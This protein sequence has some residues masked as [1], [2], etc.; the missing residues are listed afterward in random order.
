MGRS[1]IKKKR[2]Q[3]NG[4][5]HHERE[6]ISFEPGEVTMVLRSE[7]RRHNLSLPLSSFIGRESEVAEVKQRLLEVRLLTLIGP[8]G[9]G[10][11]RLA[12]R[13]AS[14]LSAEYADGAWL[15]EFAPLTEAVLIPQAVASALNVLEEAE[16]TLIDT[17]ADYLL[18]QQTLLVLDNCE[19]LVVACAQ[20]AETLLQACPGLRILATSRE[21]LG[22]P[23]EAVWSVPPLSLPDPQAWRDHSSGQNALP[24]YK[25]SEAVQLFVARAAAAFPAFSLTEQNGEWVADVC[26]KLDGMPLAIELAA[27]RV[28]TLSV[29]QIAE[30]LSDRFHL[31]K[32]GSRTA[33]SRQQTLEAALDWSYSLLSNAEQELL[34]KLSVFAGG[35]TLEAAEAVCGDH[36]IEARNVLDLLTQLANKSLV[37][38]ERVPGQKTRFRLLETIRQYGREKL[39][40]AG[41]AGVVEVRHRDWYMKMAI[42]AGPELKGSEQ[43]EWIEWLE[44][45]HDNLRAALAWSIE[46]DTAVALQLAEKL[47]QFWFMRGHHFGEGIEWLE[48]VLS[49]E[50]APGQVATRARAFRWLGTLTYLQGNYAAAR[51]AYEQ[52]LALSQEMQ[53]LDNIAEAFFYLADTAAIQGDAAAALTLYAQARSSAIDNLNSLRKLGDKWNIARTLNTLG[54]LARVEGDYAAARKFYEESLSI[55]QKLGDQRGIAVSLINLGFVAYYDGDYQ[56][57]AVFFEES[58]VL[59]QKHG[60][61]RGV[62]DCLMGLAGVIASAGQPERAARLLG[63]MEAAREAIRIG[64][65]V[66]YADRLEYDRYESAVRAQLDE[67]S[68][69]AAWAEGRN[70]TL[71]Q[72]IAYA[73]LEPETLSPFRNLKE[74]SGGLTARER[75]VAALIAQGK[76][77]RE[78][79]EAM[80]VRVK[81]VETYVTRI[82]NKLD[83]DSRVQIAIWAIEKGLRP[84]TR[85]SKD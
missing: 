36:G 10:K 42:Q 62:V 85:A 5:A 43:S 24:I 8:G 79:A 74:I 20:L 27:A 70:M 46:N 29:K 14:D 11:T 9:C 82:L 23:G 3:P 6:R 60:G 67:T 48:R 75:E 55:R 76:S 45:E 50:G 18:H 58:L 13:V 21:N 53:D 81:T 17:L 32:S 83:F 49:R 12:I 2:C 52:S 56:Q 78:I 44:R 80:T 31:L 34:S 54:E 15:V 69:T 64:S 4:W 68:F 19:H 33:P 22:I 37:V 51:S 66:S 30:R 26:C 25:K 77:N 71:E 39:R 7:P 65:S 84:P 38:V 57:A 72:A 61:K 40:A 63:S 47:G 41:E 16:R 73:L 35:W 59:F 1:W 28:Q